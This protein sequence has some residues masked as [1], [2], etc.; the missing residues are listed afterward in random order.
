MPY[1]T[2]LLGIDRTFGEET[3]KVCDLRLI[4]LPSCL[5]S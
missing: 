1:A 3:K 2:S 4:Y 5:M